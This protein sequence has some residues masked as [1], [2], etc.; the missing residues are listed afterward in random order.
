ME[1]PKSK[2]IKSIS[3]NG[4][5]MSKTIF[6]EL[7]NSYLNLS[8]KDYLIILIAGQIE[9]HRD[10]SYEQLSELALEFLM[11]YISENKNLEIITIET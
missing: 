1:Y 3:I 7:K 2:K 9:I 5:K 8:N 6:E 10:T 11:H 4:Y